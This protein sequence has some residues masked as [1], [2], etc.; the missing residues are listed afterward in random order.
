MG[1]ALSKASSPPK[2]GRTEITLGTE[3]FPTIS[4]KLGFGGDERKRLVDSVEKMPMIRSK[5]QKAHA[6]ENLQEDPACGA[7]PAV[8]KYIGMQHTVRST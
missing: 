6:T 3:K 5:M 1:M 8:R 4:V 2:P 7:Q